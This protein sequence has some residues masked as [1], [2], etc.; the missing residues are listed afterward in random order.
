MT[1]MNEDGKCDNCGADLEEAENPVTTDEHE[2]CG[3]D[4]QTSYQEEHEH[5]DDEA[6]EQQ[7]CEFC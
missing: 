1:H 7:V 3:E 4:C 2:F 5:E 6:E